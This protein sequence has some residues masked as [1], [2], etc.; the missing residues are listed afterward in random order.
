MLQPLDEWNPFD[1]L[2]ERDSSAT[3]RPDITFLS[4]Q[5]KVPVVEVVQVHPQ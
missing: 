1:L 5:P 4:R 2:L 3:A